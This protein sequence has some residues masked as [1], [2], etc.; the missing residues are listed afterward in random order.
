M[1]MQMPEMDGYAA[2]L[3]IRNDLKLDI[4][5]IA[6]TAHAL[7]GEKE[8]CLSF[9]MNE[10]IS[11]PIKEAELYTLIKQYARNIADDNNPGKII[12]FSYLKELSNG[13]VEF[14]NSIIRQF[15]IQIPEEIKLLKHAIDGKDMIQ[16]KSIAHGMKSSVSYM[17]LAS[18]LYPHL[19]RMENEALNNAAPN[20]FTH[21]YEQV[22]VLCKLSV[23]EARSIIGSLT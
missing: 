6:M 18:K 22:K 7:A 4:P 14:E 11:K 5:I 17:G 3:A 9:G 20:H 15:I 21:D 1:D 16:I 8:N 10:Y 2:T 13:D 19:Q 12:D 23:E